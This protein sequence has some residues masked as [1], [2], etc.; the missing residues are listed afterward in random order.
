MEKKIIPKI[1]HYCWFGNGEM[2]ELEKACIATWRKYCPDYEI[3]VWNEKNYD[4]HKCRYMEQAASKG[5]WSFVTDYVRLDLLYQ[6]GGIYLDTDVEL[7]KNPDFL[8]QYR[9][10]I[11]FEQED[12]VNSGQGMGAIAG[13]QVVKELRDMYDEIDFINEDGT[14][15]QKECPQYLTAYLSQKGL[16]LNN[17]RQQVGDMEIFPT[18]FFSPKNFL[19][20]RI[21]LGPDTV[22]IHHFNGAWHTEKEKRIIRGMQFVRRLLGVR[23][24]NIVLKAFFDTKDWLKKKLG[25]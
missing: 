17:K 11:G 22:S 25:R 6:Y 3:K 10:F 23:L 9:S 12:R 4:I 21:S 13:L 19:T 8:L 1:I 24:G 5:Q 2:S 7:L 20:G 16:Q 18:E 14:L 15:N